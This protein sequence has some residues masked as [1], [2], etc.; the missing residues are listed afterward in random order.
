MRVGVGLPRS[1]KESAEF[2]V[3]ITDVSWIQVPVDIEVRYATMALSA[4][5]Y[6]QVFREPAG[7]W[8]RKDLRHRQTT[9][10]RL[11]LPARRCH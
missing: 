5:T 8:W 4:R 11:R 10:V 9:V 7:H 2:A 1:S 3:G 6:Q